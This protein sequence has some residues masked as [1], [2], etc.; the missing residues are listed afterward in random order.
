M[1]GVGIY[2]KNSPEAVALYQA[3]FGLTLGYHVLN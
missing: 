1:I 3:A 2:V